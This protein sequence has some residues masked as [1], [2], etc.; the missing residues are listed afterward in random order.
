M[1]VGP[2]PS[3]FKRVGYYESWNQGWRCMNK[4]VKK[5]DLRGYTHV[6]FAFGDFSGGRV[7]FDEYASSQW[8]DF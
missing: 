2:K 6:H 7:V 5:L 4:G 8:E 3:E 1:V